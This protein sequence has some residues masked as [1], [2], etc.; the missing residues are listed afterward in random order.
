MVFNMGL[1]SGVGTKTSRYPAQFTGWQPFVATQTLIPLSPVEP[2]SPRQLENHN[3]GPAP[4]SKNGRI[5][6]RTGPVVVVIQDLVF[7]SSFIGDNLSYFTDC[8]GQADP[9]FHLVY[10]AHVR[11]VF[12]AFA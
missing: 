12:F 7:T 2:F 6:F 3:R 10:R 8:Q 5:T 1:S 9:Y 4:A 11:V